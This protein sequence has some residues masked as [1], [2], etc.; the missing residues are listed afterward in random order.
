MLG[1][2]LGMSNLVP[3]QVRVESFS[4]SFFPA[5]GFCLP[6]PGVCVTHINRRSLQSCR[7]L[8]V[9]KMHVLLNHAGIV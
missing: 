8:L 5:E 4:A 7:L 9:V 2:L 6:L 3:V 1:Y